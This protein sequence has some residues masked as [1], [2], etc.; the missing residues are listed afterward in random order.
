MVRRGK[1]VQN[2]LGD[3]QVGFLEMDK[4]EFKDETAAVF[5]MV[6]AE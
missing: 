1:D 2:P 4:E 3:W 5:T 6:R